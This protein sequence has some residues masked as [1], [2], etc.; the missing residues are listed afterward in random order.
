MTERFG[1]DKKLVQAYQRHVQGSNLVKEPNCNIM[2]HRPNQFGI[3][4]AAGRANSSVLKNAGL[5]L[6][7]P[8]IEPLSRLWND[9][10]IF[11]ADK[12]WSLHTNGHVGI[13]LVKEPARIM[14][15]RPNQFGILIAAGRAQQLVLKKP[16]G[17][18]F[19]DLIEP[20]SRLQKWLNDFGADKK[21]W[22]ADQFSEGTSTPYREA[23][24]KPIWNS[25]RCY[26][27]EPAVRS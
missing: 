14:R 16:T 25:H 10:T 21:N 19:T 27:T 6:N 11:G 12:N 24:T 3:L 8:H 15:H 26:C 2:R 9:W 18:F 1:A 22:S 17:L 13:N 20:L 23:W 5:F 7:N 4:P